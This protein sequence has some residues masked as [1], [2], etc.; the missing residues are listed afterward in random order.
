MNSSTNQHVASHD[1]V[2]DGFVILKAGSETAP[3][4][5]PARQDTMHGLQQP[6]IEIDDFVSVNLADQES[7]NNRPVKHAAGQASPVKPAQWAENTLPDDWEERRDFNGQPNSLDHETNATSSTWSPKVTDE[8]GKKTTRK[9]GVID[10]TR[11]PEGWEQSHDPRNRRP[12]YIDHNT[13]TTSWVRPVTGLPETTRPLPKGWERRRTE[14]GKIR[15]Y[16]VNHN[17]RTTSWTLP[18]ET[19][20]VRS[21]AGSEESTRPLPQGWERWKTGGDNPR[22]YYVNHNDRTTSWTIPEGIDGEKT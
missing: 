19:S 2:D 13:R 6:T 18:G 22:F 3:N 9:N 5:K 7:S 15:L 4:G 21:E 20:S 16:Y 1:L 10:E 14:D 17:E 8:D 11:L 12:Y